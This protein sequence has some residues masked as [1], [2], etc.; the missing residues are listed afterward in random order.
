M[1]VQGDF[2]GLAGAE[3]KSLPPGGGPIEIYF[4]PEDAAASRIV[5]LIE[6]AQESVVFLAFT[7]TSAPIAAALEQRAAEGL[8]V[9]GVMDA[10]QSNNAGSRQDELRRAGVEL[11]FDGNPDRMH[12]KVIVID[13]QTVITGSYNFSRSAE[14]RNDENLVV[15]HDAEVAASYLEEFERVFDL[16]TP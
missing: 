5:E 12:H 14:T 11:R 7:L 1:F 16:G 3:S 8:D 6:G 15:L 2:G 4:S 9:R 13:R 10:G